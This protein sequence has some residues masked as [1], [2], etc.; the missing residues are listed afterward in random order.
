MGTPTAAEEDGIA[1]HRQV[2][3]TSLVEA[4]ALAAVVV[5]GTIVEEVA[6]IAAVVVSVVLVECAGE[7]VV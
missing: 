3:D 2:V 6:R 1:G 7:L 5:V 4:A